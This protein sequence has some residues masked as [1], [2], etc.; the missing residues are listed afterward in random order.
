MKLT[1]VATVIVV[2][3]FVVL[4]AVGCATKEKQEIAALMGEN[5]ELLNQKNDLQR[6]LSAA[7]A[8]LQSV[9]NQLDGRQAELA[10]AQARA[11][12]LEATH[13]QAPTIP[14]GWER[15]LVSDKVTVG[16]DVLFAS[17]KATLTSQ[18]H[19]TLDRILNDLKRT[20]PGLPVRVYGHTDADPIRK[21]KKL[22][23]DNLDLSANRAMA[24]T[25]YLISKG[26]AAKRVETIGMGEHHPVAGN[27]TKA[28]KSKNR[29]VEIVVLKTD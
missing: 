14:Q 26:I 27:K 29:R 4:S 1:N 18:G 5:A 23:Q 20:Y 22:W 21:T 11:L 13:R 2:S 17:G 7:D 12:D 15:G 10:A 9:M 19:R 28:D 6:Q 8:R 3:V 24:V 25:R 16:T